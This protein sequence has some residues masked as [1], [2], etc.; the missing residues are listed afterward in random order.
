MRATRRSFSGSR[1]LASPYL[2]SAPF[3]PS[4][5]SSFP[6]RQISLRRVLRISSKRLWLL[7]LSLLLGTFLLLHST[8][9]F[10]LLRPHSSKDPFASLAHQ[11]YGGHVFYP[12]RN[13][14]L[15]PFSD[16]PPPL[17]PHLIHL[18]VEDA[19]FEWEQKLGR[20]SQTLEEAVREYERRYGRRPPRGFGAWYEFAVRNRVQMVDEYDSVWERVKL[21]ASL[22]ASVLRERSEMLQRDEGFWMWDK[23]FTI[24]VREQ[25]KVLVKEGPMKDMGTRANMMLR[26]LEGIAEFL[27]D[28]N[29]TMTGEYLPWKV[30]KELIGSAGHDVPWVV[31]SGEARDRHRAA[32]DAGER[33]SRTRH[34]SNMFDLSS[35]P[36]HRGA[37]LRGSRFVRFLRRPPSK[38]IPRSAGENGALDGW[39]L[40]CSPRSAI[41]QAHSFELRKDHNP[42]PPTSFIRNHVAAMDVCAHP[43][44]QAL[45]GFTAW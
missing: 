6:P 8:S 21:F 20:Q 42:A 39:T 24:K 19:R 23:T 32:A 2:P 29:I 22:P 38:L 5:S 4:L 37:V 40:I 27:P 41:R 28:L 30:G 36:S 25:G 7:L 12:A 14:S 13:A 45:H 10:Q 1:P 15:P 31:I 11:Q 26:L 3:S 16:A 17:Q 18:L 44:R 34:P 43:S 9:T 35:Y 33:T